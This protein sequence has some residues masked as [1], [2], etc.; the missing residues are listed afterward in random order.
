MHRERLGLGAQICGR[1]YNRG[2]QECANTS[3]HEIRTTELVAW[4]SRL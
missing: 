1:I 4:P 3:E 2:I